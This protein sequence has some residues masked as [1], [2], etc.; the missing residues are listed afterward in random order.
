MQPRSRLFQIGDHEPRRAQKRP[1]AATKSPSTGESLFDE[2]RRDCL[3]RHGV[4]PRRAIW[5][6]DPWGL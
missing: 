5:P 1:A 6:S 3:L 4:A 2:L